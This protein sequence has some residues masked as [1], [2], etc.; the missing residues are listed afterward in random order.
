M[1]QHAGVNMR[2]SIP[3]LHSIKFKSGA[4]AEN[5]SYPSQFKTPKSIPAINVLEGAIIE[6]LQDVVLIGYRQDGSEY[7][8]GS[9]TDAKKAGY[10]FARGH[11]EMLR[12][13][14]DF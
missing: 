6:G 1:V 13:S 11:L 8:A 14:D 9:F 10:M 4:F 7:I 12:Q 2:T 5:V 3:K